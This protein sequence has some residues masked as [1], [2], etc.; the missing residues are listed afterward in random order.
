MAMP[1][2]TLAP[3]DTPK[4]KEPKMPPPQTQHARRAAIIFLSILLGLALVFIL[5]IG[6]PFLTPLAYALIMATVFYPIYQRLLKRT[7]STGRAALYST[8]IVFLLIVL[9][10][11]FLLNIAAA[12]AS[13]LGHEIAARSAQEGGFVHF[14]GHLTDKPMHFVGRFVDVSG[15][16]PE[17]QINEHIKPFAEKLLPTAASWVGGIVSLIAS[18]FLAVLAMYFLLRDSEGIL[19][20]VMDVL[21]IGEV[22]SKRLMTTL[23]NAIVANV[24]GVFAVGAAQGLATGI[25]LFAV[26]VSPAVLLGILATLCSVIPVVGTGLVWGPAAIYLMA[27]GHMV[28]GIVLLAIGGGVI[29]MLDNIIRP[30]VVSS[31][32]QAN[33]LVLMLSMLGG[34]AA[35]GFL[36]LFIGPVLIALVAAVSTML[37]EQ[38]AQSQQLT[39]QEVST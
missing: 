31:A 8:A 4:E 19:Q 38:L 23:T 21:P 37:K 11:A 22:Y 15:F 20:S 10:V 28:K 3:R 2:V 14:L 34:V 36:G 9:P 16:D 12:E 27:T 1:T 29:S 5:V 26:G 39:S 7:K 30:L 18:T 33:G 32:V 17:R 25:A 6:W 13:T 24:H 35:F